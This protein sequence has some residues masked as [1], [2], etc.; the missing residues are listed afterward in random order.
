MKPEN[1]LHNIYVRTP[2]LVALMSGAGEVTV[3]QLIH[4][5][6]DLVAKDEVPTSHWKLLTW[7]LFLVILSYV[8]CSPGGQEQPA[9]S[10]TLLFSCSGQ[11]C[12]GELP[13]DYRQGARSS[14]R[15]KA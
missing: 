12:A 10:S 2:L 4:Q 11:G 13:E 9:G 8:H 7:L 14:G 3:R 15:R 5:G 6:E 1:P